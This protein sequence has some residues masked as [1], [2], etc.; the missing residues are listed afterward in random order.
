MK[1]VSIP[2]F[3]LSECLAL[4]NEPNKTRFDKFL[5]NEKK[6][7]QNAK[8]SK[9]KHQAW[10][11]GYLDHVTETMNIAISLYECLGRLRALPFTLND[12]LVALFLHDVEKPW[13]QAGHNFTDAEGRKNT[14]AIDSF[15]RE[16]IRKHGFKVSA[17]QWNAIKYA[18]GEGEDYDPHRLV[19]KPLAAFVHCCDTLS[20]R[21]WHK[22]PLRNNDS[23]LC[24]ARELK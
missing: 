24:A 15:R 3:S 18:E 5:S 1:S 9:S 19:Q 10:K 13:K 6:I 16:I 8:G 20:A 2:Y 22:H 14:A 21:V 11:G 7:L 4:V 23:W 17:A 12:A